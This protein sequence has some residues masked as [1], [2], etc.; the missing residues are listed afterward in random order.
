MPAGGG[1]GLG[2]L[3]A[4]MARKSSQSRTRR[5]SPEWQALSTTSRSSARRSRRLPRGREPR[6]SAKTK[7]TRRSSFGASVSGAAAGRAVSWTTRTSR[8]RSPRVSA[9]GL[10]RAISQGT[11]ASAA[12]RG[13]VFF[14]CAGEL[15]AQGAAALRAPQGREDVAPEDLYAISTPSRA[16]AAG[17]AS[18]A[19]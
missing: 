7:S 11:R 1:S 17:A 10:G 8:L 2:V 19:T 16:T 12:A 4:A 3:P 14:R 6:A 9:S 15:D 18:S 13:V 5:M